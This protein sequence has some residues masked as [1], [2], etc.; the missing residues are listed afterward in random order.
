MV[1]KY[2]GQNK[3]SVGRK[4]IPSD[5]IKITSDEKKI[6][7]DET[8]I[9][10]DEMTSHLCLVGIVSLGHSNSLNDSKR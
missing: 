2:V 5:R 10:S 8:K 3:N 1:A 4:K 9:L 6:P 7:S